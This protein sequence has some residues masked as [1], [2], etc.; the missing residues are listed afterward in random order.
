[1]TTT[2]YTA[3]QVKAMMALLR[4]LRKLDV[5]KENYDLFGDGS[6]GDLTIGSG[7]QI[8][9]LHR[10]MYFRNLTVAPGVTFETQGFKIFVCGTLT[11]L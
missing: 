7:A 4:L 1:M 8:P 3:E 6:D 2:K 5:I 9:T 11:F 10:D